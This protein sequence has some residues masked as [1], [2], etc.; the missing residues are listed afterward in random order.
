MRKI[1]QNSI[2]FVILY[3]LIFYSINFILSINNIVFMNWIYYFSNGIIILGSIIGIY[4]LILKIKNKIKKNVFIIIMT[5]F[6]SIVICMYIY[7]SLISYTPEYII[8]K[9]GKKMVAD[10]EGFHHTYIYYYEYINILV[11]K[12][13]TVAI[14]HYSSGSHNPFK[15]DI[16]YIELLK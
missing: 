7:I 4:Q 2:I 5:I 3:G 1:K 16:N 14:E 15:T 11:R 10:V 9:D 6:S 12:K 8:I 13:S